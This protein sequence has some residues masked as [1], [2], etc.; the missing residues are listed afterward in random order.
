MPIKMSNEEFI[1]RV[2]SIHGD[3]FDYSKVNFTTTK[4]NITLIDSDG[5]EYNFYARSLLEGCVPTIRSAVDK[6]KAFEVLARKIHGDKYDYSK[7]I[8]VSR[9]NKIDIICKKHGLFSQIAGT[10]LSGSGCNVCNPPKDKISTLKFIEK[11]KLSNPEIKLIGKYKNYNTK[12]LVE[13]KFG[14]RFNVYPQ[15]ILNGITPDFSTCIDKNKLFIFK[16][17]L[18]HGDKYCY[19]KT[20]YKNSTSNVKIICRDHGVF[21]QSPANHL[22]GSG[23]AKCRD[24][25]NAKLKQSDIPGFTLRSWIQQSEN[26]SNFESYKVYVILCFGDGEEF[27]KIGR[28]FTSLHNRFSKHSNLPYEYLVIS[29]I[30]SDAHHIFHL[31]NKLKRICREHKY[32]VKKQFHGMHECFTLD[33]LELIKNYINKK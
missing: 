2:R 3:R 32:L 29:I 18:I 21:T 22:Q 15:T 6:N 27:I 20:I 25:N 4:K 30:E 28:T 8:Y 1:E 7:S 19:D 23:C 16:A 26:S 31:E 9:N 12:V 11:L 13:D 17:K 10:H 14:N 24:A 33:C 5:I